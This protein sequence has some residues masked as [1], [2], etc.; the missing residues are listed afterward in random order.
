[1]DKP[2][3]VKACS[4]FFKK[5]VAPLTSPL[6]A[7]VNFQLRKSCKLLHFFCL[8]FG[9]SSVNKSRRT[10]PRAAGATGGERSARARVWHVQRAQEGC[11]RHDA[12]EVSQPPRS[13]ACVPRAM[14]RCGVVLPR[15]FDVTWACAS[16]GPAHTV[17]AHAPPP[18]RASAR[19]PMLRNY[20]SGKFSRVCS[21]T[22]I[23]IRAF[24]I[25]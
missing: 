17:R 6:Y 24:Y 4:T 22:A 16:C 2:H 9:F 21:C 1:M 18:Q 13:R 10:R 5:S 11:V 14:W 23:T 15:R 19:W 7:C 8:L 20:S 3:S 12:P 25:C